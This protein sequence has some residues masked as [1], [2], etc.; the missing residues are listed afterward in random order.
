M[1]YFESIH[2]AM[3]FNFAGNINAVN[4]FI[5]KNFSESFIVFFGTAVYGFIVFLLFLLNVVVGWIYYFFNLTQLFSKKELIE[6]EV[7]VNGKR[8]KKRIANWNYD[9]DNINW[10]YFV[11]Y[12]IVA[13]LFWG[14][15][16]G[17]VIPILSMYIILKTILLP[18][19]FVAKE[20]KTGEK[21]NYSKLLKNFLFYKKSMY[22]Y[23]VSIYMVSAALNHLGTTG[24]IYSIIACIIAYCFF[25]AIYKKYFPS[26]INNTPLSYGLVS[27][28]NAKRKCSE[29]ILKKLGPILSK[30]EKQ[31]EDRHFY[32]EMIKEKF[33]N[34]L[35]KAIDKELI[36]KKVIKVKNDTGEE[37]K[38]VK[39]INKVEPKVD[40]IVESKEPEIKETE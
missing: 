22:M 27:Y 12:L 35:D 14:L 30:K 31:S 11:I 34:K 13:L 9:S 19:F 1:K 29:V 40:T 25:P 24:F 10:F 2:E 26:D 16:W 4:N 20:D 21:Y 7:I 15:A 6:V 23:L 36:E 18:L 5:N 28:E 32:Q 3:Y 39:I 17:I 37:K 33:E 38:K 8:E